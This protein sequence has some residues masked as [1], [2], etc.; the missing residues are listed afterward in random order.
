MARSCSNCAAVS[1]PSATTSIRSPCARAI[2]ARTMALPDSMR[3]TKA[4]SI[5]NEST[6]KKL[7]VSQ[8]GVARPKI[9]NRQMHAQTFE[10]AQLLNRLVGIKHN[11]R[12][13]DLQHQLLGGQTALF[14]NA[15]N[16]RGDVGVFQL[17]RRQIN[18]NRKR[19]VPT[20]R[21]LR[22]PLDGL[23]ARHAQHEA[24]DL[25]D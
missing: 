18:V 13:G 12:F 25:R 17:A 15:L 4:R 5:L 20:R 14:Q 9:V 1:T 23:R 19:R 7:Q 8:A 21:S 2:I 16:L 10:L 3:P 11:R 24:V 22:V 6:G